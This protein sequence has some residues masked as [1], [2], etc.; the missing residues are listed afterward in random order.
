M[1]LVSACFI[2]NKC[3]MNA[4]HNFGYY[5]LRQQ[6][7]KKKFRQQSHGFQMIYLWGIFPCK[8]CQWISHRRIEIFTASNNPSTHKISVADLHSG[9]SLRRRVRDRKKVVKQSVMELAYLRNPGSATA[10]PPFIL[11]IFKIP[12][13]RS[14]IQSAQTCK[15]SSPSTNLNV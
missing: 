2:L 3:G 15:F 11:A 8:T 12:C 10:A 14:T 7:K 5:T 9:G 13:S 1:C 4:L 6:L